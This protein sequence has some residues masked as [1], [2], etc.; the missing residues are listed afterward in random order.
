MDCMGWFGQEVSSRPASLGYSDHMLGIC[1]LDFT[2]DFWD[3]LD[4]HLPGVVAWGWTRWA[5]MFFPMLLLGWDGRAFT[6]SGDRS[7]NLT[8]LKPVQ[9]L[10]CQPYA[11]NHSQHPHL[12]LWSNA[13]N[14]LWWKAS[15]HLHLRFIFSSFTC[16]LH[17]LLPSNWLLYLQSQLLF[18]LLSME[19]RQEEF[20]G[21]S[22]ICTNAGFAVPNPSLID[23][24][25]VSAMCKEE[26]D[27]VSVYLYCKT[28]STIDS[29]F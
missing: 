29:V 7:S 5:C 15:D 23:A 3:D 17:W 26:S 1:G 25:W 4:R 12:P 28:P 18:A 21:N 24:G 9:A 19:L 13:K 14:S 2:G 11:M 27:S 20:I 16:H 22:S 8:V 10:P 6:W